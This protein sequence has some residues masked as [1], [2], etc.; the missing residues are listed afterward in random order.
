LVREK[1]SRYFVRHAVE[2]FGSE[3]HFAR[4]LGTT[5]EHLRAWIS[6]EEAPAPSVYQ[7]IAD[8]LESRKKPM[9]KK[10]TRAR[11]KPPA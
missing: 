10:K 3:A 6:G 5:R 2:E 7:A 1:F 11:K 8:L 9:V 4:A